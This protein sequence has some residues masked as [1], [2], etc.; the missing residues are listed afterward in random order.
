VV[1]G[2]RE[3]AACDLVGISIR[4]LQRWRCDGLEDR[5]KGSE[6][7][8]PRKL[9]PEVVEAVYKT[10]NEDRF[11]DQTP[12][13]VVATLAAEAT[14]LASASTVYRVLRARNAVNR[15][16]DSKTPVVSK[17]P[18][19]RVAT[20]PNQVWTW[21]ITWLT[22]EV[23]G[24]W[25]YAYVIMDLFDRSVVGWSIHDSEDGEHAREL[26][27][28]ACRDQRAKPTFVHSDNGAPMKATT[29]VNFLYANKILPTTNRPRVS[30]DNP[31]SESLFKTVKYR[32]GYPRTFK[33]LMAAMTWFAGF[34]DWYNT[35]HLHSALAYLT[36]E[37]CRTGKAAAILERRNQ[38]LATARAEHPLRWGSRKAKVYAT[39][40]ETI[41]HKRTA[42]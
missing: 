14:Y 36:P 20:A 29:L 38:T 11:A 25:F 21:D 19:E 35:K 23:K 34:V 32:A 30:N 12:E 4:T 42:A 28:R 1:E 10:A 15:R 41:L 16:Q 18:E 26:F 13:Q 31:F 27:E 6:K 3:E 39:P 24:I 9:P 40:S 7:H 2:A 37:Q 17:Q 5:R 8:T 22:T 33:N